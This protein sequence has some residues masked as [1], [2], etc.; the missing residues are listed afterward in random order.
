MSSLPAPALTSS[1]AV[2]ALPYP[3]KA[4]PYSSHSALLRLLP[5]HGRDRT[6]LDLG[7]GNGYLAGA[8]AARGFRVTGIDRPGGYASDFPANVELIEW[9]LEDGLPRVY[10]DFDYIISADILEHLRHPAH[11]LEQVRRLMR[12]GSQLIASLPNSGHLYF[13]WH[14]ASGRFPQHD[15]GLFDRT[16]LHFYTW[17]GWQDL[18]AQ[19]GFQIQNVNVTS[20]PLER[21]FAH[22]G[23]S[24]FMR[25]LEAF[26]YQA[27]RLWKTLFAYQFVVTAVTSDVHTSG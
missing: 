21:A 12:P 9:D 3:W 23:S 24:S 11:L 15:H 5:S 14:V 13:R 7:C 16:H 10:P 2:P 6:V 18:F 26:A 27:A 4:S 17:R 20:V 22:P 8:L 19:N 25:T 1:T